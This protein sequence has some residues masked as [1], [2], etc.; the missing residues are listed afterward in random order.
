M[1]GTH[2]VIA[3]VRPL[4][5][6]GLAPCSQRRPRIRAELVGVGRRALLHCRPH[7]NKLHSVVQHE[8]L[9]RSR[10][11]RLESTRQTVTRRNMAATKLQL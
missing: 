3:A 6:N 10:L 2:H 9:Q 4:V 7:F 11:I 1:A 8:Q 5:G